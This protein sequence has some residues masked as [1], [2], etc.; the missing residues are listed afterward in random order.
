MATPNNIQYS[1]NPVE[2]VSA[3]AE[4][5]IFRSENATYSPDG[6]RQIIIP[7]NCSDK[8]FIDF[9]DSVISMKFTNR[10]ADSGTVSKATCNVSLANLIQDLTIIGPQGN[11]IEV[12]RDY[13]VLNKILDDYSYG[14]NHA[15]SI[16]NVLSGATS[17]GV[18]SGQ[19]TVLGSQALGSALATGGNITMVDKLVCATLSNRYL[20]PCGWLV[21]QAMRISIRLA[22]P[23]T[24]L[25]FSVPPTLAGY[26]VEDVQFRAKEIKFNSMFN[27]TFEQ[28]LAQAGA[29]GLSYI[30]ETFLHAQN[31]LPVGSNGQQN[32]QFSLNP[33]SAKYIVSAHRVESDITTT[34]AQSLGGR[35]NSAL[36]RYSY[37]IMG[38]QMPSQPIDVNTVIDNPD[39]SAGTNDIARAYT[40]VLDAFGVVGAVNRDGLAQRALVNTGLSFYYSNTNSSSG[41]GPSAADGAIASKYLSAITLE[42]FDSSNNPDVF[43]GMN[44][45]T[46]GPLIY[47][48]E[49]LSAITTNAHRVDHY[50]ACDIQLRFTI[51]GRMY[52][53]K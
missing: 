3:E 2:A 37:D 44:L 20:V 45:S 34:N 52:S 24:A 22:D 6:N 48:P 4:L 9:S 7:L 11:E 25:F 19:A 50:I 29:D 49:L 18:E 14:L 53:I 16:E 23:E 32:L 26:Q 21:G 27:A 51:D 38:K 43:S 39:T 30:G 17:T 31:N 5:R 8:S 10:S 33:R 35:V 41:S 13:N 28:T 1:T 36:T 40:Q 47:R 12:I 42:D 46:S 15:K